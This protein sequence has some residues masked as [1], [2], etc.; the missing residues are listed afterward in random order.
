MTATIDEHLKAKRKRGRPK[1]TQ[2]PMTS[3]DRS[4]K[5]RKDSRINEVLATDPETEGRKP[6]T[7]YVG[8][9]EAV[10]VLWARKPSGA[11]LDKL[12]ARPVP[13]KGHGPRTDGKHD[14][15]EYAEQ[16]VRRQSWPL[17]PRPNEA[18]H[19]RCI[20]T[21]AVF[22]LFTCDDKDAD[23]P[24]EYDPER[25]G[26]VP[27]PEQMWTCRICSEQVPYRRAAEHLFK[28]YGR[29][30]A[31]GNALRACFKEHLPKHMTAPKKKPTCTALEHKGMAERYHQG[32]HRGR[33]T[34]G[35]CKTEL[36]PRQI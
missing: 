2:P 11:M 18:D 33:F 17:N 12:Y 4:R 6:N 21:Y 16:F 27:I 26:V 29:R 8:T 30:E 10:T 35:V 36:D 19:I 14:I 23:E 13:P 32:G 20:A 22:D 9:S 25:G 34:C 3:T 24:A 1:G 28:F 31:H 15:P 7:Y 5:R